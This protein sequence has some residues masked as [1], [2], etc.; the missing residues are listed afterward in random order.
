MLVALN[1]VFQV[2][3]F[4]ALGWFYLSV[5]PGWLGLPQPMA[6]VHSR[7]G[8]SVYASYGAHEINVTLWRQKITKKV[9]NSR[10]H[11]R[12]IGRQAALALKRGRV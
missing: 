4:G 9:S 10:R 7:L 3:A 1:S 11:G 8:G 12:A 6:S 2:V 5:L